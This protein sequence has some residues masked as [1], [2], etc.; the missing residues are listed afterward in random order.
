[1]NSKIKKIHLLKENNNY[2][3]YNNNNCYTYKKFIKEDSKDKE[4]ENI[5]DND[6][7]KDEEK[8][9]INDKNLNINIM[10]IN[11]KEI[12]KKKKFCRICY[13]EDDDYFNPLVQP[14]LCSGSLKYIHLEC[15]KYW[16]KTK[17]FI[18]TSESKYCSVYLIK[19]TQ[20]E[21][22]KT[23]FP[24][25]VK[26]NNILYEIKDIPKKYNNYIII[27]SFCKDLQKNKYLF[28]VSLDN[29]E[30]VIK[31]GRSQACDI[32]FKDISISRIHSIIK[33]GGDNCIYIEDNN[34]KFGTLILIQTPTIKMTKNLI[35]N[36]Q[37]GR[38]C[39]KCKI[40]NRFIFF[41]CCGT[42]NDEKPVSNYYYRQ[43]EK[44][45]NDKSS[46][47]IKTEIAYD[48]E[49]ESKLSNKTKKED[50]KAE[51][52][53]KNAS[54]KKDE[55]NNSG[56]NSGNIIRVEDIKHFIIG[57]SGRKMNKD[58]SDCKNFKKN[59]LKS[60]SIEN[61]SD[62]EDNLWEEKICH[63]NISSDITN[64]ILNHHN[65]YKNTN[66]ATTLNTN[67]FTCFNTKNKSD[68]E[69]I[70]YKNESNKNSFENLN[71]NETI[72]ENNSK[73]NCP[74]KT[75]I[76]SD[77]LNNINIHNIFDSDKEEVLSFDEEEN[78]SPEEL[79]ILAK[80]PNKFPMP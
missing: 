50:E 54:E 3:K 77:F 53:I 76:T 68:N 39:L 12:N 18:L 41:K 65:K 37:I 24:D 74:K 71:F 26:H 1:M 78:I 32:I 29:P 62:E 15:L 17:F 27:E 44:D 13:S 16:I 25:F 38:T 28:V 7:V 21:L 40:K 66:I 35:L 70:S 11:A 8:E 52:E 69:K 14:C 55:N 57:L 56:R 19:K 67:I 46:M 31:V 59:D 22:C 36:M 60:N 61:S 4:I 10:T 51:E 64:K 47:I 2:N 23:A 6:K 33:L 9:E 30:H 42:E 43:N 48:D 20:C 58:D 45:V 73:N 79:A 75:N 34:S 5:N 80:K 63:I 72:N 49:E